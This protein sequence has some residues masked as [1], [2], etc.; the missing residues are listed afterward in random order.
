MKPNR[1]LEQHAEA[2]QAGNQKEGNLEQGGGEQLWT[3]GRVL[4]WVC[5]RF[6]ELEIVS[7][8]LDAQLILAEVLGLTRVE[9][10]TRLDQPLTNE[11][12]AKL[13]QVVKRRLSGEPVAYILGKKHWHDFELLVD[14]RVLIPRPETETLLDYALGWWEQKGSPPKVILDLCTGSGCLA[15]ALAKSFPAARVIALDI[16][17]QALELAS[18]NEVYVLSVSQKSSAEAER[19]LRF[20]QRIQWVNGDVSDCDV[21]EHLVDLCGTDELLVVANPPYVTPE[22]WACCDSEVRLFEPQK[23]LVAQDAGLEVARS[24]LKL[25]EPLF[26]SRA[27]GAATT[28]L[29]ELSEGQPQTLFEE[30]RKRYSDN[31]EMEIIR[32]LHCR[33]LDYPRHLPFSARDY[34][35][36]ARY[37]LWS[38]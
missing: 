27:P 14:R 28:L 26:A 4:D 19:D 18:E 32:D 5:G 37:L 38:N 21:R 15:I 13:R 8:R 6:R 11:E 22:E 34:S 23:A 20:Q 30:W 7:A 35:G 25:W 24:V 33:P 36:K 12:R 17:D 10:Y 1:H 29:M 31:K 9:L 16:C 3:V 2:S